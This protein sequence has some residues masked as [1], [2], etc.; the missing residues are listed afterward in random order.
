MSIAA[1]DR[2]KLSG[3]GAA[4]PHAK[5]LLDKLDSV[6]TLINSLKTTSD[7]LADR[8]AVDGVTG[9]VTIF[10]NADHTAKVILNPTGP[11]L[12]FYLGGTL[13]GQLTAEGWSTEPV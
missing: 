13:Q 7:I 5:E 11:S 8:L 2:K 10:L 1:V 6:I 3:T 12:D 9:N 4:E